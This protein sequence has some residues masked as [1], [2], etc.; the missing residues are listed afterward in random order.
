MKEKTGLLFLRISMGAMM[1]LHGLMKVLKG[2]DFMEKLGSMPPFF[3]DNP[4]LHTLLG[5]I[6]TIIELGGGILLMIGYRARE[7][8]IAIATVLIFAFAYH[9]NQISDFESF[10]RNAWPLEMAFVFIALAIINP[11]R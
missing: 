7:A 6:A 9:C 1:T 8:S 4:T 2:M 3:P 5:I 10:V 11:K